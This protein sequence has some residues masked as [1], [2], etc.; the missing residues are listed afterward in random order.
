MTN[1]VKNSTK[2]TEFTRLQGIM[3]NGHLLD[4]SVITLDILRKIGIKLCISGSRNNKKQPM[5]EALV[6][7]RAQKEQQKANGTLDAVDPNSGGLLRINTT[8]YLNVI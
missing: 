2:C 3:V 7:H 8:R 1:K 6:R 4:S 5:C